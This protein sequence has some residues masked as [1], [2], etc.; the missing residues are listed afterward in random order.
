MD[1]L[2]VELR[3]NR[4]WECASRRPEHES[5]ARR[6]TSSRST[7]TLG[8]DQGG[9]GLPAAFKVLDGHFVRRPV[10][11]IS[12]KGILLFQPT[13][14][15]A[16]QRGPCEETINIEDTQADRARAQIEWTQID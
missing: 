4:L 6:R 14:Q 2:L 1:R 12:V 9:G 15:V 10:L 5:G 8:A 16:R 13:Q 3:K 7:P 11:Q